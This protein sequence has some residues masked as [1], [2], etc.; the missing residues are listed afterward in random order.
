MKKLTIILLAAVALMAC[1]KQEAPKQ[2][3]QEYCI[4]LGMGWNLGNN[5]DAHR[6]GLACEDGF[7]NAP[8]TAAVFKTVREAGFGSVRIPCTWMQ[9]IGEA[10]EYT[11]DENR[12][13]RVAELAHAAHAEGLKV[14]INIHHDGSAADMYQSPCY[15]LAIEAASLD[16]VRNAQIEDKLYH[17]WYNI[18]KYFENEGDWLMFETMNEVQDG[19][20]GQGTNL[21]DGGAQYRLLNEWNQVAVNAIR[22][23]GGKNLERYI[24]VPGYVTQPHLT[25]PNLVLPE[26]CVEDHLLVAVHSYDPWDYAGSGLHSEWG[27]TSVSD[28][29]PFPAGEKE[30]EWM[31]KELY[32]TFV[33][34]GVP[35]Y[36]GEFGCVHRASEIDEAFRKYYIE[37]VCKCMRTYAMT[38]F[39]WDNS[40]DMTGDDAF[41]LIDHHT[42]E[43]IAN[44]EEICKLMV[45]TWNNDD[46]EYTLQSVWDKAPVK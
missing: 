28:T 1:Q 20:W 35:V 8:A 12:L 37:Y 23:A 5:M 32:D 18:A 25:A 26:D 31:V 19:R 11:I 9:Y 24:G 39:W 6:G 27:H 15:W 10:P 13:A 22:A 38:G 44:G 14:I 40:Y 21:T 16:S 33:A 36:F 4:S 41:G 46:P 42:G 3:A 30:Y 29:V 45:E 17:T 43:Y 2:T 7:G 34:K